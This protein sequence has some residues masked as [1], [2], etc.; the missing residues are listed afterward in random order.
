LDHDIERWLNIAIYNSIATNIEKRMAFVIYGFTA[1]AV[2]MNVVKILYW[3]A[4]TN[5]ENKSVSMVII[6]N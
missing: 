4:F 3:K 6:E 1:V 2:V 5:Y